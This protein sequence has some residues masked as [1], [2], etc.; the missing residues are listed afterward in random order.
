MLFPLFPHIKKKTSKH[1]IQQSFRIHS[2]IAFL[3]SLDKSPVG[4]QEGSASGIK[5]LRAF[6]FQLDDAAAIYRETAVKTSAGWKSR[7]LALP[8][9]F[10][11]SHR[12]EASIFFLA[13]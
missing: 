4:A 9:P 11:E 2:T 13:A 10:A 1:T 5:L 12:N 3:F 6:A 7:E 8:A